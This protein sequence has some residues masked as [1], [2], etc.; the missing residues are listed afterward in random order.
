[1]LTWSHK[2]IDRTA[3]IWLMV[4]TFAMPTAL[5]QTCPCVSVVGMSV[6]GEIQCGCSSSACNGGL[7]K[8][9]NCRHDGPA[10][11]STEA[12]GG[13]ACVTRLL[14]CHCDNHCPC[15][16][17]CEQRNEEAIR[18]SVRIVVRQIAAE[19]VP[20]PATLFPSLR[21]SD[22]PSRTQAASLTQARTSRQLCAALS[23]FLI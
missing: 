1:M 19:V 6:A 10:A 4:A 3:M 7:T 13:R 14:T 16:C 8:Q 5:F 12:E 11:Q 18:S 2:R 22:S 17:Q 23:R 15:Q 9:S 20:V 21:T